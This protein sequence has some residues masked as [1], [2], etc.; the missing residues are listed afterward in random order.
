[1]LTQ[2]YCIKLSSKKPYV[3]YRIIFTH[4]QNKSN[5]DTLLRYPSLSFNV[6]IGLQNF[7]Q[8]FIPFKFSY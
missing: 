1:M 5:R 8:D 4:N 6:Q 3:F 7:F 2:S